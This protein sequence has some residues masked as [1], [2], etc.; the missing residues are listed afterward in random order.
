MAGC[1][2]YGYYYPYGPY[3]DVDYAAYYD[4]YYG[5]FNGGY[6]GPIYYYDGSRYQRDSARHFRRNSARGYRQIQG[7][8]PPQGGHGDRRGD[9]GGHR[10]HSQ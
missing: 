10:S 1:E 3:A 8:A 5:A 9:Q 6:W 2:D 4:G 7:H